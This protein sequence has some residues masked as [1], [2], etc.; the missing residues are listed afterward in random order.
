MV[1]LSDIIFSIKKQFNLEFEALMKQRHNQL[2]NINER[3][4]RIGE[5]NIELKRE[6]LLVECKRNIMEEYLLLSL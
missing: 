2:D 4:K 5:I 1:L 6:N 3:N